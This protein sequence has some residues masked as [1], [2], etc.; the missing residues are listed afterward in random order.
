M[1]GSKESGTCFSIHPIERQH[2][3]VCDLT[4]SSE[5]LNGIDNSLCIVCG[6]TV[7]IKTHATISC[8]CTV[9]MFKTNEVCTA[10]CSAY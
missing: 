4:V 9:I 2:Y 6:L 5:Q 3:S 10:L 7:T 8:N 1:L